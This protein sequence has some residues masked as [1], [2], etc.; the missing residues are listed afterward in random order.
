MIMAAP[1]R[2][3]TKK[4]VG[5]MVL[6]GI[7]TAIIYTTLLS[8][9]SLV[10]AYF[11]RGA[12]YALLPIAGAFA[13]SYFHGHFTGYFWTVLGIE[14]KKSN[15]VKQRVKAERSD[16]REPSATATPPCTNQ[17]MKDSKDCS[18]IKEP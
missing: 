6:F 8:S 12:L 17:V 7:C 5:K 14:A 13:L 10:T 9:Q 15:V 4:P 2:K 16:R 1:Y 3:S 11:T 18:V